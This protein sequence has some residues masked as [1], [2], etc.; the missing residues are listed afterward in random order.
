M[1]GVQLYALVFTGPSGQHLAERWTLLPGQE[2][3]GYDYPGMVYCHGPVSCV[4]RNPA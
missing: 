2:N 4:R 1:G 3:V